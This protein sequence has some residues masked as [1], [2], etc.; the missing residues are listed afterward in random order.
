VTFDDPS[1]QAVWDTLNRS[2][3]PPAVETSLLHF[4][5]GNNQPSD[6]L[7]LG[8][9]PIGLDANVVIRISQ[10]RKTD[11]IDFLGSKHSGPLVLPGQAVHEIW[12]NFDSFTSAFADDLEKKLGDLA[13]VIE[14]SDASSF[15]S[16]LDAVKE[17]VGTFVASHPKTR[18]KQS[19][20]HL[21]SVFRML[22]S[23]ATTHYV[24][25]EEFFTLADIRF[26]TKTPPGYK[27]PGQLGDFYIWSD[28]LYGLFDSV[29]QKAP[30]KAV[31][32]VTNDQKKDWVV[33]RQPHPLLRAEVLQ[34]VGAELV[35]WSLEELDGAV[36]T[37]NR[38][39]TA[40]MD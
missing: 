27:D 31:V 34:L 20:S 36:K 1:L 29:D 12:N 7:D 6:D 4:E 16:D 38:D 13:S 9:A 10:H 21:E 18:V 28:F 2:S 22:E 3:V 33:D 5:R 26:R 11:V 39:D 37:L 17:E 15:G 19:Y 23:R 32:F 14:Q 8:S 25:R 24:P 40:P 35:I 30:P